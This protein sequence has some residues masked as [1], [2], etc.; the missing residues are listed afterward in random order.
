MLRWFTLPEGD[1]RNLFPVVASL[2]HFSEV[3]VTA[4]NQA[5]Q[6]LLELSRA[7]LTPP[8]PPPQPPRP[9][10]AAVVTLARLLALV[11]GCGAI[12]LGKRQL[13]ASFQLRCGQSPCSRNA[14]GRAEQSSAYGGRHPTCCSCCSSHHQQRRRQP[15]FRADLASS[16][17]VLRPAAWQ[18]GCHL[19]TPSP[20]TAHAS[21]PPTAHASSPPTAHASPA[22]YPPHPA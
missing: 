5:Q 12:S 13:A 10:T 14:I 11:F 22:F 8:R 19:P 18:T 16:E 9:G 4:I 20:P 2:C 6:P 1:R 15:V 17:G 7:E 3:D 21:S